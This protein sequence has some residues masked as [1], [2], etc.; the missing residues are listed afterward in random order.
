MANKY[1]TL[2]FTILLI[3][4][5]WIPINTYPSGAPESV[6]QTMLPFHGGGIPPQNT[7]SPFRIDTT[8]TVIGQGQTMRIEINANPPELIFEGFMIQARSRNPPYQVVGQF[9]EIPDGKIKLMNCNGVA[10]SA[11][12]SDTSQKK[13]LSLEWNAPVD[14]L[15]Q[16]MF[17]A[18]VAQQYHQF[19]TGIPSEPVQIVKREAAPPGVIGI[20]STRRPVTSTP[21][22]VFKPEAVDAVSITKKKTNKFWN[23]KIMLSCLILLKPKQTDPFYQGCGDTKTCFGVPDGCLKEQNCRA[24]SS[25][26]VR[27]EIYEFELKSTLQ[28]ARYVAVGISEDS[29]MGDDL[30]LECVQ[31][32]NKVNLYTSWLTG[33]PNYGASRLLAPQNTARLITSSYIN[34]VIH[35]KFQKDPKT[36]VQ[37]KTID[38][39]NKQYHLLLATGIALKDTGVGYHQNNRLATASPF[40]FSVV[41]GLS[42]SSTLLL[43]LHGAFMVAAWIGFTSLGIALARYFKQ[44]WVGSQLCGKDQWFAW[45]RICMVTTWSLTMAAFIL[46]FVEIGGWSA[47]DNPHA[48]LGVITTALCFFQPIGAFFRPAPNSKNRPIF[49]W[50][51]W[52]GGNLAHLLALIT[53][54]FAVK[55]TKAELP[56]WMDWILVAYVAFHVCM[57]LIFSIAGCASDRH[58]SKRVNTFPMTDMNGRNNSKPE[59]K[60]DAPFASFRKSMLALYIIGLIIL[61]VGLIVVIVL[62]PIGESMET[63]KSMVMGGSS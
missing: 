45:H 39:I 4:N 53:I 32:G 48:I 54:F 34:G 26:N 52:L 1:I 30:A 58:A 49:N 9:S 12:H 62:A 27:G 29:K 14:F 59:R 23:N 8:S 7:A 3:F 2:I 5:K 20:S 36:T 61:T 41:Q 13:G 10:T 38:L 21:E 46:I 31:E 42:G 35:C 25:I 43:R 28:N 44:T 47:E 50:C 56:E 11:T 24:L 22:V 57:H 6:C 37:G 63:L 16:I 18:T 60:M 40:Y 17:N 33:S 55:L 15:G 51:H 19:W